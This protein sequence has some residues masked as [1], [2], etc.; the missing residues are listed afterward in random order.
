MRRNAGACFGLPFSRAIARRPLLLAALALV[1]PRLPASA[2]PAT[3][4][5]MPHV[6]LLG[7]SIF[8]NAAY[9]R[10]G[11]DV[12]R[13]LR[14]RLPSGSRATLGAV[15]GA[16]MAN[17]PAQLARLPADATHLVVSVGGNDALRHT[18]VFSE[19]ARAVAE[20]LDR[21][22]TIRERFQRD[23]AAT[24]DAVLLR[25]LPT[26]ACTIYEGRFPEPALRRIAATA[27]TTLNDAITRE[28]FA[29]G[30]PLIDLR[31]LCNDDA[32]FAN[33]IEPSVQGGRK[34]AAA[35]AAF[36]RTSSG[37]PAS[38]GFAS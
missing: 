11:P 19:P 15:D 18:G 12:I 22:A 32:D 16:V 26:A 17:I 28:A 1:G 20:A 10:G 33:P 35:I 38:R 14:E 4:R 21:L 3:E 23:Y 30:I 34:I 31:V 13:Q 9:V 2:H 5:P 7:D 24:L 29:R 37:E 25:G 27:L 36:L 6:V 8:D